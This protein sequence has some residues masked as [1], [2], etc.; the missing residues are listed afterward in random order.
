MVNSSQTHLP[1]ICA[2]LQ[3][4]GMSVFNRSRSARVFNLLASFTFTITLFLPSAR[5]RGLL[6]VCLLSLAART[7]LCFPVKAEPPYGGEKWLPP[8]GGKPVVRSEERRVGKE[9]R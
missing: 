6:L 7:A 5:C 1:T 4:S 2:W 8:E 3:I 9:C